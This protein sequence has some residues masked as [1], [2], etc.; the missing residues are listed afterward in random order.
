MA[1][2]RESGTLRM[3]GRE[4]QLDAPVTRV[5]VLA[6][7]DCEILYAL[8]AGD[9]LVGRGE[10]CDYPEDVAA[11]PSV[12]SGS[13]T[14]IEQIVALSPQAVIMADDRKRRRFVRGGDVKIRRQGRNAAVKTYHKRNLRS[15]RSGKGKCRMTRKDA[16]N[17]LHIGA[18]NQ[19][20]DEEK[21]GIIML[22]NCE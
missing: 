20:L 11:I 19:P 7:S 18:Q 16:A 9:T 2:A 22:R 5:V 17:Y 8:G 6:A 21:L 3:K 14:N 10:Y 12:Q 4:I 15:V 13:E 1:K